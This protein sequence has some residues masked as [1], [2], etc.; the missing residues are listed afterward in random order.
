VLTTKAP[1]DVPFIRVLNRVKDPKKP[2]NRRPH[3][4]SVPGAGL[5]LKHGDYFGQ[6]PDETRKEIVRLEN[7]DLK[8]E[9]ATLKENMPRQVE[10][11][12]S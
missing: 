1:W 11:E 5:Y 8:K 6:E 2:P 12:V 7:L 4:G 9:L 10:Q 3:K